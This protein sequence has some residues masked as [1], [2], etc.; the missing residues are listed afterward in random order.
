MNASIHFVTQQTD[1]QVRAGV[2][3]SLTCKSSRAGRY[4]SVL[5]FQTPYIT[6]DN[7]LSNGL[8]DSLALPLRDELLA[9]ME[10]VSL[11]VARSL[12]RAKENPKYAHFLTSGMASIVTAMRDGHV[13]EVGLIGAEGLVEAFHLLGP[14]GVSTEGLMQIEGT[15]LRIPFSDLKNAFLSSAPLRSLV[16]QQV[17]RQSSIVSQLAACNYFHQVEERLA[18]WLLMIQDLLHKDSFFLTQEFLAEMIGV[19]RPTVTS[20]AVKLQRLGFIEYGRGHIHILNRKG[21]QSIACECYA[22]VHEI[23]STPQQ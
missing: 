15:A 11:P 5:R 6:R 13:L 9:R 2:A 18:R 4:V 21:L 14:T 8:L 12:Y 19:R 23:T 10:R 16:L 7:G 1:T 3:F 20:A 22:V 17:Q